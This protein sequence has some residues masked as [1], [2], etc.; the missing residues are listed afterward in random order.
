MIFYDFLRILPP[1]PL[2]HFFWCL[3]P[4]V[5]LLRFP[6]GVAHDRPLLHRL[7]Q[8]IAISS[9]KDTHHKLHSS[10]ASKHSTKSQ[11]AYNT[12]FRYTHQRLIRSCAAP[13]PWCGILCSSTHRPCCPH[14]DP[15]AA[16]SAMGGGSGVAT[17]DRE[18]AESLHSDAFDTKCARGFSPARSPEPSL[19]PPR[20]P[21]DPSLSMRET[22]RMAARRRSVR[23]KTGGTT[24][25]TVLLVTPSVAHP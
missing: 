23:G 7:P 6:C 1:S 5:L 12:S 19:W 11:V 13:S 2:R 21:A 17:S 18:P 25:S 14:P 24:K 4:V 8:P 15:A 9:T 16:C 20:I 22:L 10:T 3:E